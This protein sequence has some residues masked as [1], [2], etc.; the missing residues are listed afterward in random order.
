MVKKHIPISV[1]WETTL[2][3]NM[4]CIHCGSSA[5]KSR[6]RE[7]STR[8]S[9]QLCDDLNT[10]GT[11]VIS[12]MGGEPFLRKDWEDIA[13]YIRDLNMNVTIMSNGLIIDNKII[14]K[15]RKID[16]YA[17]TISLDGATAETHNMIRGADE[18]FD[19]CMKSIDLLTEADLPTTVITTLHKQ[20]IN[21]LPQIR[22]FLLNR[23]IAWQIQ[24]AVP[25]GRFPQNLMLSK[26]EY[27]SAALFIAATKK[28]YS[29]KELPVLGAHNFGYH[30]Q[31]LPNLMLLPWIGCQAGLTALGIQSD[32]S[33]KGCLSLPDKFIE[34][35]IRK[36]SLID[37]WNDSNLFSY[38]RG[39]K[40]ENLENQCRDCTYGKRCKGGCVTVSSSLTGKNHCNP[41]CLKS[42]EEKMLK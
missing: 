4:N 30:S 18:S 6:V 39:F 19:G 26:K 8:E 17:V 1:V 32:G 41:Y 31:I 7:L 16:P 27:Y 15:L 24:M 38:N 35:N 11:R 37:I 25:I 3:C 2:A 29:I 13:L 14:T 40:V 22:D 36:R 20:N 34:G 9:I 33:V 42:I 21:D 28:K 5:G 10:L 23:G 12:M